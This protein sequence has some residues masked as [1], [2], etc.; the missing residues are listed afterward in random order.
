MFGLVFYDTDELTHVLHQQ[1]INPPRPDLSNPLPNMYPEPGDPAQGWGL[2][3]FLH[4]QDSMVHSKHTG[5]WAGLRS[6]VSLPY[7]VRTC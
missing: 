4:L 7:P 6:S 2:T 5:W 1:G 3:F